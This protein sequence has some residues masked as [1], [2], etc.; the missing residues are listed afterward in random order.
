MDEIA[1][2]VVNGVGFSTTKVKN[3]KSDDKIDGV[4]PIQTFNIT[5]LSVYSIIVL[6]ENQSKIWVF[7]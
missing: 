3:E 1:F 5:V 6:S 4:V 2:N 7:I